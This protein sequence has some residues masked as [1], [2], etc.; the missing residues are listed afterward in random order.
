MTM[1]NHSPRPSTECQSPHADA[2]SFEFKARGGD[3][4]AAGAVENI[5]DAIDKLTM[6]GGCD[7]TSPSSKENVRPNSGK[8]RS[9]KKKNHR[10]GHNREAALS[11]ALAATPATIPFESQL[12]SNNSNHNGRPILLKN[13][14][15]VVVEIS[16]QDTIHIVA[17]RPILPGMDYNV[18]ADAEGSL[19]CSINENAIAS[20]VAVD[21]DADAAAAAT[22]AASGEYGRSMNQSKTSRSQR[23]SKKNQQRNKQ[24]LTNESPTNSMITGE[25]AAGEDDFSTNAEGASVLAL[26]GQYSYASHT[27]ND[28]SYDGYY[29]PHFSGTQMT[30]IDGDVHQQHH[31]QYNASSYSAMGSTPLT[32]YDGHHFAYNTYCPYDA[33]SSAVTL[34]YCIPVTINGAVY[35]HQFGSAEN[36]PYNYYPGYATYEMSTN[37]HPS[38]SHYYYTTHRPQT[39]ESDPDHMRAPEYNPTENSYHEEV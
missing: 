5:D 24:R 6:T 23:K 21:A 7:S 26:L 16:P 17:P 12:P 13:K 3:N 19:P 22:A 4:D 30:M 36:A 37:Q 28:G 35:Y 33:S 1:K 9:W 25:A 2:S 14:K 15:A 38:S 39:N 32:S 10:P 18:I 29:Y 34:G 11:S 8:K 31:M 20:A 27:S